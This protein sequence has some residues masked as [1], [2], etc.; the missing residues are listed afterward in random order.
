M[1]MKTKCFKKLDEIKNP[2]LESIL[3]ALN[4]GKKEKMFLKHVQR[5]K[6]G[7][8]TKTFTRKGARL[9]GDLTSLLFAVG[10]LTGADTEDIV[11][12]LDSIAN[13]DG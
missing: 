8:V 4:G 9:Y 5:D 2:C 12:T 1:V 10:R 6:D 11:E 7:Y 3:I 13:E